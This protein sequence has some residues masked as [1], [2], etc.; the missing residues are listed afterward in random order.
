[1]WSF[2]NCGL[3]LAIS[4]TLLKIYD[5]TVASLVEGR[6]FNI[7][8]FGNL[9]VSTSAIYD[10]LSMF[11]MNILSVDPTTSIIAYFP[12]SM[13]MAVH[14]YHLL[15]FNLTSEDK[16]HHYIFIPFVCFPAM[17]MVHN[18][19][20]IVNFVA[21]FMS[22]FPGGITYLLLTCVKNNVID[23]LTEKRISVYINNYVRMPG[24]VIGAYIGWL[25]AVHG[26]V[27]HA[28]ALPLSL[29]TAFNGIYYNNQYVASITREEIQ[30]R[31]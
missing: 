23:R 22:G 8:F 2:V 20:G 5:V 11:G 30:L 21:F 4:Y 31:S 29:L 14:I 3:S 6:W 19:S 17:F 1:M 18:F 25:Y 13:I 24:L 9:V 12:T 15:N 7:H 16:F 28:I 27:S 10:V 26:Y